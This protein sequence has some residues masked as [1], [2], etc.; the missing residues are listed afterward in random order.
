M[1][2]LNHSNAVNELS[3]A[4]LVISI[5]YDGVFGNGVLEALKMGIPLIVMKHP[6]CHS[7]NKYNV[8]KKRS[9]QGSNL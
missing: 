3:K 8:K 2:L 1:G 4:D 9:Q 5:N 7:S 6:G